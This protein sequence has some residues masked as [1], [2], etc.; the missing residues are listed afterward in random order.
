MRHYVV[1]N[2]DVKIE[3]ENIVK[4]S[5]VLIYT[6]AQFCLGLLISVYYLHKD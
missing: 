4:S 2:S 3:I 5:F 1:G 6:F